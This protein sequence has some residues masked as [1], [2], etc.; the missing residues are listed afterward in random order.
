MPS[1]RAATL[2]L[3]CRRY[4]HPSWAAARYVES[5]DEHRVKLTVYSG[6]ASGSELASANGI[7]PDERWDR[8]DPGPGGR[9]RKRSGV[10]YRTRFLTRTR[11]AIRSPRC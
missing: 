6:S 5:V 7:E 2:P 11:P 8:G 9:P 3:A 4:Q 10:Q 1:L